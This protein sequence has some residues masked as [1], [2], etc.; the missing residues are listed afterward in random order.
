M[1]GV[2]APTVVGAPGDRASLATMPPEL[3]AAMSQHIEPDDLIRCSMAC[4]R[5]RDIVLHSDSLLY[6]ARLYCAGKLDAG[7]GTDVPTSERL[8]R[9][10]EL[11]EGWR[12][13]NW[14]LKRMSLVPPGERYDLAGGVV[15]KTAFSGSGLGEQARSTTVLT[16]PTTRS[17]SRTVVADHAGTPADHVAVDPEQD[18]LVLIRLVVEAPFVAGG[19]PPAYVRVHPMTL[20]SDGAAPHLEAVQQVF[21]CPALPYPLQIHTVRI[22]GDVIGLSINNPGVLVWNWKTGNMIYC[23]WREQWSYEISDFAFLTPRLMIVTTFERNRVKNSHLL[24]ATLHV[25]ALKTS[26]S[27]SRTLISLD[28]PPLPRK[29]S[30]ALT[31]TDGPY[32][33]MPES[34]THFVNDPAT[35]ILA[36]C[37]RHHNPS[38]NDLSPCFV[39]QRK[40]LF[41]RMAMCE[42]GATKTWLWEEWDRITLGSLCSAW[43][44]GSRLISRIEDP[45]RP[46][47]ASIKLLDFNTRARYEEGVLPLVNDPS[48]IALAHWFIAPVTT[49]L[50]YYVT[51]EPVLSD[52]YWSWALDGQRLL[53]FWRNKS[54]ISQVAWG[55]RKEPKKFLGN[56]LAGRYHEMLKPR[57]EKVDI[58]VF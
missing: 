34:G 27:S 54:L 49:S 8:Q 58:F 25:I 51:S 13:L 50:P 17:L 47:V 53:G 24:I 56:A 37:F 10:E 57:F 21:E 26:T 14:R 22:A 38:K 28:F 5:L 33:T 6:R 7:T 11:E 31:I 42:P 48:T 29:L 19:E 12:T 36:F 2:D 15:T 45:A 44:H 9:L 43:V 30:V 41:A 52:K 4:R 32:S 40:E 39:V 35:E 3:F 23:L 20:S 46:G 16:L 55:L 1:D 18:L